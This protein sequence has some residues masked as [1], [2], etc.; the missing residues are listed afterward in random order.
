MQDLQ[1]ENAETVPD[2]GNHGTENSGSGNGF[3]YFRKPYDQGNILCNTHIISP[4]PYINAE[5]H[6][7]KE[8][9]PRNSRCYFAGTAEYRLSIIPAGSFR[10]IALPSVTASL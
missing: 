2:T 6:C 1:K 5:A 7:E 9:I 3:L 8:R 4:H 10:L